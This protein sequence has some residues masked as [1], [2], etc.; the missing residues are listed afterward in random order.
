[1]SKFSRSIDQLTCVSQENLLPI[2]RAHKCHY[3]EIFSL[4]GW[5]K[6]LKTTYSFRIYHISEFKSQV[7]PNNQY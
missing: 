7:N 2:S 5:V 4:V 3:A 6:H 1:M